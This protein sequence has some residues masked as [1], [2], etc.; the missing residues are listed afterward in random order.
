MKFDQS[1]I[2]DQSNFASGAGEF[3]GPTAQNSN[4]TWMPW[5]AG[6]S[7]FQAT[8]SPWSRHLRFPHLL[9]PRTLDGKLSHKQGVERLSIAVSQVGSS[10]HTKS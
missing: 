6:W 9:G 3:C 10:M 4:S 5:P 2:F 1:E 7:A 8:A